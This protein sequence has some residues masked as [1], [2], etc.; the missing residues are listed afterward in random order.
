MHY[1]F[2]NIDIGLIHDGDKVW[3]SF[4]VALCKLPDWL[5][6]LIWTNF[7][8][9]VHDFDSQCIF[10]FDYVSKSSCRVGQILKAIC[11]PISE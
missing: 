2:L 11:G 5:D 8:R 4:L 7:W 6:K 9:I 3:P 1:N 10:Q